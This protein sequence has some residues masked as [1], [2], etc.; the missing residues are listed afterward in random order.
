MSSGFY[1]RTDVLILCRTFMILLIWVSLL[2][3]SSSVA[4][5]HF[6]TQLFVNSGPLEVVGKCAGG[7]GYCLGGFDSGEEC[8]FLGGQC[9]G[10]CSQGTWIVTKVHGLAMLGI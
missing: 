4:P 1:V 5:Q 9:P 7:R 2:P 10:D 8:A 6:P 3:Y